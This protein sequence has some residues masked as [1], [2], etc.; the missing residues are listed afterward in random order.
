MPDGQTMLNQTPDSHLMVITTNSGDASLP[1]VQSNSGQSINSDLFVASSLSYRTAQLA[2][3]RNM[4][5]KIVV[6]GSSV[7][8]VGQTLFLSYYALQF[9]NDARPLD[10]TISG[11][12]LV[13]A[14]RHIVQSQG[15]Y[16]TVIEICKSSNLTQNV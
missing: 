1:Y 4:V 11:L 7:I 13:T 5:L 2:L 14:V 12:Y 9:S 3:M 10:S 15:V 16:H 6:P 8:T